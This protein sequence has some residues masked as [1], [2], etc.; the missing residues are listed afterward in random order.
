MCNHHDIDD[1]PSDLKVDIASKAYQS[2]ILKLIPTEGTLKD[3]FSSVLTK[4]SEN[5]HLS[6]EEH[7]QSVSNAVEALA[8]KGQITFSKE[9]DVYKISITEEGEAKRKSFVSKVLSVF[10]N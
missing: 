9:D 2:H 4:F 5:Y 8:Q 10:S 1:F 6:E 7:Q 3:D